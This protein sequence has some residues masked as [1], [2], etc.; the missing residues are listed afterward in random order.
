MKAVDREVYFFDSLLSG[1]SRTFTRDM[2]ISMAGN[3]QFTANA[4]DELGQVVT[5]ASNTIPIAYAPPTPVP[6]EAPLVTP[7]APATNALPQE[8]AAPQWISQAES[9]ADTAKWIFA[10][11]AGVL[12]LLLLIG[13]V[14]RGHSKSQS[15]KAMDHL[16]GANYRDY[17]TAPKRR[18]RSEIISGEEEVKEETAAPAETNEQPEVKEEAQDSAPLADTLK[19]VLDE[20]GDAAKDAADEI[21]DAAEKAAD[22]VKETAEE[23]KADAESAAQNAQEAARRRRTG[24]K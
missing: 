10:G 13:A 6:T 12:A 2:E 11:I 8:T 24:R 14:R 3:F 7:P 4:K 20:S 21:S 22:T 23:V 17:S 9:A 18:R 19:R 5:F 1:E 16:E 15:N